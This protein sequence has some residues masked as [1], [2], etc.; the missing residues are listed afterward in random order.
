MP[1]AQGIMTTHPRDIV[2]IG[3]SAGGVEALPR[4]VQQLPPALEAAILVV[5]HL[6]PTG[7]PYL[8]SILQRT[9]QLRVE[10]AEQGAPIEHRRIIIAPPDAHLVVSDHHVQLTKGARE[11][12]SRPSINKL[13]RS[14]AADYGSRVIG[15]LLT[16][17]LED[18][19]AG[20]QAIH[21]AGGF[22]IVQDPLDAAFPE[23]PT[24]ALQ[25]LDPDRTLPIDAIGTEIVG[26]IGHDVPIVAP[27]Q[28]V[29]LE[30]EIDRQSQ[31][32]PAEMSSLGPQTLLACPECHGPMW[33]LGD[34]VLRRFRC[35]L[36][37]VATES[38]MLSANAVEV[39]AALWS[40]VRALNDRATTLETLRDDAARIGNGQSAESYASRAREARLQVEVARQFMLE[41]SRPK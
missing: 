29:A 22:V 11:N 16:G 41:L 37:H 30:A 23:L 27:P 10:W 13:F 8:V 17:M 5:Q 15:V 32:L 4:I 21:D 12:H 26:L 33:Q 20:L 31:A 2:V 14:A 1:S 25:A 39:E 40:A 18:G 19:V 28:H 3:C 34:E 38:E 6:A 9:S 24:R 35:Y 36:G 7:T